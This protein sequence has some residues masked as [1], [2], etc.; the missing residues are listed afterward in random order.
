MK[1]TTKPRYIITTSDPLLNKETKYSSDNL[2]KALSLCKIART[3]DPYVY[4]YDNTKERRVTFGDIKDNGLHYWPFIN[5]I[6][7]W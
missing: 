1:H 3:S 2:K 6:C 7:W 4:I 5:M